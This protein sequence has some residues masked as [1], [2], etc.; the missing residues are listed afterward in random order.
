M[1]VVL[2]YISIMFSVSN[3]FAFLDTT[4]F[5]FINIVSDFFIH[6]GIP[7]LYKIKSDNPFHN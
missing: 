2:C 6:R 5:W 7:V 4:Y 3:Y 1:F